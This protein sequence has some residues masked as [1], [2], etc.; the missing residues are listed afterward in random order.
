MDMQRPVGATWVSRVHPCFEQETPELLPAPLAKNKASYSPAMDLSRRHAP[1]LSEGAGRLPA[2]HHPQKPNQGT[3][4]ITPGSAN[5]PETSM[6]SWVDK[7]PGSCLT[8]RLSLR[9]SPG[10][11]VTRLCHTHLRHQL[12]EQR[13]G[14]QVGRGPGGLVLP[15][16][17]DTAS[18]WAFPL[19]VLSTQGQETD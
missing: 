11:W 13:A 15:L 6:W 1:G 19:S 16:A 2:H 9:A 5:E 17:G 14:Q 8:P 7:G 4:H 12:N 3:A 10:A 18:V